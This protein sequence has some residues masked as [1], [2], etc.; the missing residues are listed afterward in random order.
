MLALLRNWI[1]KN[2]I[3]I[4]ALLLTTIFFYLSFKNIYFFLPLF[5][6]LLF[7]NFYYFRGYEILVATFLIPLPLFFSE[8]FF[9]IPIYYYV[10]FWPIYYFIFIIKNK[11]GWT[12]NL[13]LNVFIINN[14]FQVFSIFLTTFIFGVLI[15]LITLCGFKENLLSALLKTIFSLEIFWLSFFTPFNINIRTILN[16]IVLF[17]ILNKNLL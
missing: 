15:F 7:F 11:F 4:L 17:W 13:F 12:L 8:L 5:F 9:D 1:F 3:L 2:L 10:I 6:L 14:F 16:F